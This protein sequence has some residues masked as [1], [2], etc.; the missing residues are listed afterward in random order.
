[1]KSLDFRILFNF[2][3]VFVILEAAGYYSNN[4]AHPAHPVCTSCAPEFNMSA[5]LLLLLVFSCCARLGGGCHDVGGGGIDFK[6][7]HPRYSPASTYFNFLH[8][9]L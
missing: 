8:L 2:V 6:Q 5:L 7:V 4:I 3:F 9:Y 1:M